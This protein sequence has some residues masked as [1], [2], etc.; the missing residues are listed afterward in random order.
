MRGGFKGSTQNPSGRRDL[1]DDI[2][3]GITEHAFGSDSEDLNN[4]LFICCNAGEV[5]AVE[6]GVLE[7]LSL[8]LF[9][10]STLR[11]KLLFGPQ[12]RPSSAT[13]GSLI[14]DSAPQLGTSRSKGSLRRPLR[15]IGHFHVKVRCRRARGVELGNRTSYLHAERRNS[16]RTLY[17][18]AMG[19][20]GRPD[21]SLFVEGLASVS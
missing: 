3:S 4:A 6:D 16:A 1:V 18:E 21:W 12:R 20:A 9:A 5:G 13:H 10:F 2:G 14:M 19:G 8:E 7:G 11:R 15:P 17:R